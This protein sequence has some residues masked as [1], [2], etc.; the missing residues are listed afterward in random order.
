MKITDGSIEPEYEALYKQEDITNMQA[1][2]LL[3]N[4]TKA[5]MNGDE[6][7]IKIWTEFSY[8]WLKEKSNLQFRSLK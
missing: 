7:Q 5:N 3:L 2:D 4:L 6:T 8:T 1:F